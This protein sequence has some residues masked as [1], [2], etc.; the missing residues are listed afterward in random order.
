MNR[1]LSKGEIQTCVNLR[2]QACIRGKCK[3]ELTET[4]LHLSQATMTTPKTPKQPKH[5]EYV[6]LLV[7]NENHYGSS[8]KDQIR[9]T[10]GQLWHP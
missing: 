8:S 5:A 10:I 3:Q 7:G 4:A 1:L 9:T 2:L 6:G